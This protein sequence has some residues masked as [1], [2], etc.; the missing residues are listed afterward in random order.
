M[1]IDADL[2]IGADGRHST[3]R[4]ASSLRVNDLGAPIDV[5]W[6]RIAHHENDQ[7]AVLGKAEN[8]S[9]FVMIY[10]GDY[11]QC[12]MVIPKGGFDAIKA[13]GIEAFRARVAQLAERDR[14]DELQTWDDVKLLTV[15]VDRLET[16]HQPGLLFIGDAAHA[17]SPVGGVGINLAIQDAVAAANILAAPLRAKTV[18]DSDLARVQE[19][20]LWPTRVIQAGQVAV[21]DRVLNPVISG[22]ANVRAPWILK[23]MQHLTVLQRI[24][25]RIIGL[26]IRPEHVSI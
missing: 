10:R 1:Q 16:W 6:M 13:Q 22:S 12:A 19:R 23:L 3:L 14:A 18:T 24:P 21:Q 7:R 2:V 15:T 11:W 5:L 8:G 4:D 25:A 17:M 26:G 20:R 9:F